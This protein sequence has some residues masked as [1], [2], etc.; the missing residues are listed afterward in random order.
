MLIL[1][2]ALIIV[3]VVIGSLTQHALERRPSPPPPLQ[4][5]PAEPA[6]KV[7]SA[8]G[9]EKD[10]LRLGRAPSGGLWLEMEG[11]RLDG[12]DALTPEQRRLLLGTLADLRPWL[13]AAPA[14]AAPRGR[15]EPKTKEASSDEKKP[16]TEETK[17]EPALKSMVEQINDVLQVNLRKSQFTHRDISLVEGPGGAVF[18]LDDLNKYEG[19]EAVPE[20]EIRALI[21][22]AVVDWEKGIH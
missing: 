16:P 19:I 5:D 20:Q 17:P 10:I 4:P 11:A 2:V 14:P 1:Y 21:R 3:G 13:E 12:K 15:A 22:Q 8:P 18:V 9:E 7:G 6:E